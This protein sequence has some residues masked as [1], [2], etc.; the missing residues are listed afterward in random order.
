VISRTISG[1][2]SILGHAY[3]ARVPASSACPCK[4]HASWLQCMSI[5]NT[6]LGCRTSSSMITHVHA[7]SN[8]R[9][10]C[11]T[12]PHRRRRRAKIRGLCISLQGPCN[13]SLSPALRA[14]PYM[15]RSTTGHTFALMHAGHAA[16]SARRKR[17]GWL[18]LG[19]LQWIISG[20]PC[21][22][23]DACH[24]AL[25]WDLSATDCRDPCV[26]MLSSFN[27]R[28]PTVACSSCDA[29]CTDVTHD[30]STCILYQQ[31]TLD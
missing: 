15:P 28:A 5:S 14:H 25:P 27:P 31:A 1:W 13:D 21:G 9:L 8:T 20:L 26:A 6:R 10:G 16:N 22:N 23:A 24:S 19:H 7:V 11:R 12:S 30:V 4:Q 29:G 17:D 18:I 2:S 3:C